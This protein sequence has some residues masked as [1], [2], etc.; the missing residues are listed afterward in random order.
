MTTEEPGEPSND[1]AGTR[2]PFLAAFIAGQP[3]DLDRV[4]L[5]VREECTEEEVKYRMAVITHCQTYEPSAPEAAPFKPVDLMTA[6]P[7]F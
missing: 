1:M 6:A 3:V 7:P 4:W 2:S 5:S